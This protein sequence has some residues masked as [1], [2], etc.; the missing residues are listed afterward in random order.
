[1]VFDQCAVDRK[2]E[3]LNDSRPV[4][5]I[6]NSR[7]PGLAGGRNSGIAAATGELIAFCDDDD[8]WLPGKLTAQVDLL[9][10]NPAASAVTSGIL[11]DFQGV[12]SERKPDREV[13][14]L[15]D[16]LRSRVSWVHP[17]TLVIRRGMLDEIGWVDEDVPGGYG[18]DYEFLLRVA[19]HHPILA[20]P[21][22]LTTVYW[23]QTSYYE[24]KWE[25]IVA[26]L[27]WLIDR[28]PEFE[29]VPKGK[30]RIAGQI[31]FANA[32][33]GH[34]REAVRWMA[35][36]LRRNPLEPRTILA[37]GVAT[38][39]LSSGRTVQA[40]HRRGRGI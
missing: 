13:V 28:Y 18:E 39:V 5:A 29:V 6:E 19:K 23:H 30:A 26:G 35:C 16:L 10:R 9:L 32:S 31:A 38:R 21:E 4:R 17:S 34:R 7:R 40:L 33:L 36:A 12:R 20:A 2:L 25:T 1:M 15:P 37:A 3:Q 14:T 11:V 8:V 22:C 27:T 24:A